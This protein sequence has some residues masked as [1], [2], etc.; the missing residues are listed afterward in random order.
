MLLRAL[1]KYNQCLYEEWHV[2][3]AP[4]R[5]KMEPDYMATQAL[6]DELREALKT[7]PP[8]EQAKDHGSE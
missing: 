4:E 2:D 5:V 6:I 1:E 7:V 3:A 8:G